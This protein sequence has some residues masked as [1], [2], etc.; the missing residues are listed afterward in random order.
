S[1]LAFDPRSSIEGFVYIL[2]IY[3]ELADLRLEPLDLLLVIALPL[4]L[5]AAER[6]LHPVQ[7]LTLP[8]GDHVRVYLV[9]SGE[10][11]HRPVAADRRQRYLCL[12]LRGKVSSFSHRS[13]G[14]LIKADP[15]LQHCPKIG[16]H[17]CI[18]RIAFLEQEITLSA[19]YPLARECHQLELARVQIPEHGDLLQGPDLVLDC[20]RSPRG[21]APAKE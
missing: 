6:L 13:S 3:D 5:A 12:K 2:P 16:G 1:S 14:F 18:G 4:A 20:H 17:F 15:T 9:S 19:G 8:L 7:R 10:F 21:F 11:S